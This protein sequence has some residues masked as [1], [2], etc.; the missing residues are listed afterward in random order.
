MAIINNKHILF[1]AT[2]CVL[3]ACSN[4]DVAEDRGQSVTKEEVPVTVAFVDANVSTNTR[5]A[6]HDFAA[7]D[8]LIAH[9][10]HVK[11]KNTGDSYEAVGKIAKTP[12]FT[13]NDNPTMTPKTGDANTYQTTDITPDSKLYW[14]DFSSNEDDS[15]ENDIRTDGHGLQVEWGYCYNGA[16]YTNDPTDILNN[17]SV[18]TNQIE[19]EKYKTSDLLWAKSQDMVSYLHKSSADD[20]NRDGLTIPYTHAMS[21]AT[22]ILKADEGF[23]NSTGIFGDTEVQLHNMNVSGTFTASTATVTNASHT[24]ATNMIRMHKASVSDDG[25]TATFEC[26]FVPTELTEQNGTGTPFM[27]IQ[28]VDNN[29]YYIYLTQTILDA[30]GITEASKS[31]LS[32]VNYQITATLNKAK[33]NVT[34]QLTDWVTKTSEGTAKIK[35]DTDLTNVTVTGGGTEITEGTSYDI[36]R[37]TETTDLAKATTR[38]YAD[39][40]WSNAPEIYWKDANTAYYFR[41]LAKLVDDK[42]TTVD[43]KSTAEQG[44]DLLWATT[45]EHKGTNTIGSVVTETTVDEGDPIEPRTSQVP[46]KFSHAMSKVTF[47]LQTTTDD[48]KVDLTEATITVPDLY[49]SGTIDVATGKITGSGEKAALCDVTTNASTIVIPQDVKGKAITITLKDG[50]TY[51]YTLDADAT[52]TGGNAYTYTV[53]LQKE[54]IDFRALIKEWTEK[55]GSGNATLDWD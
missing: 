51:H 47:V 21:K 30:W 35:F 12:V 49:T 2:A 27:S 52:W 37:G 42:I 18:E 31:T 40:T 39:G 46:M 4:N 28:S 3:A 26:V 19:D 16:T 48:S 45:P 10:R 41:G 1:A 34:A 14:D 8:K 5:A 17:Y 22:I 15:E 29:H 53:T 44:T 38:T 50:T 11:K 13:V 23:D 7:G 43:G 20:E 6:G 54:A 32:G 9:I 55:K 25:K 24:E 36:F 33:V